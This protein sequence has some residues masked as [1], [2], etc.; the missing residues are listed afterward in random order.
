MGDFTMPSLGADME[1]GTLTQW[2]VKPGDPVHRGDIV[3]VVDTEKSTI[4]IEIFENGVVGELVVKEGENVPVGSVLA[5]VSA[6]GT[7]AVPAAGLA[8]VPAAPIEAA[9]SPVPEHP[10]I[11]LP[12]PEITLAG[13]EPRRAPMSHSPVIRHLAEQLGVDLAGVAASGP[14]GEVT[15]A[16]VERAAQAPPHAPTRASP[17]ARRVAGELGIDLNGLTG[18]GPGGA[19]VERDLREA[20]VPTSKVVAPSRSSGSARQESLRRAIGALMARS[21]REI[22]HYYLSTTVDAGAATA[23]LEKANLS[24]S[25]RDRL[26]LPVLLIKATALAV[27]KAPEVNGFF[28]DGEFLASEAVH[29]GVAISL[30][31]GGVIAPAIHD[32]NRL[33]LDE[34][35][36]KLNDLVRRARAGVLRSSEMSDPTIT[37]SNLGDLGV[38]SVF[39]VIYPPQVAV[40]GFGAVTERPVAKDGLL[41]VRPCLT[42]TLSADH[43]VSDGHRGGRFLAQIDRLLQEPEKL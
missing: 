41:G 24:R 29:V 38:E 5:R 2:L 10:E 16:D 19:V 21:K 11:T 23:W 22:P 13:P 37:V 31:A 3:A 42:A 34:L 9:P 6:P 18:T 8:P 40:V 15:R 43:R 4:E 27:A 12:G 32:A 35:M 25:V 20:R 28:T 30:R 26:V 14:G 17:L 33:S 36:L 39:G 1:S 7:A